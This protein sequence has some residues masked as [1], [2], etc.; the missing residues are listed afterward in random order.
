MAVSSPPVARE[1]PSVDELPLLLSMQHL[2][3][4]IPLSKNTILKAIADGRF[5]RPTRHLSYKKLWWRED[6][7]AFLRNLTAGGEHEGD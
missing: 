2:V 1:A 6:V 3:Q 7:L 5:P 4:I